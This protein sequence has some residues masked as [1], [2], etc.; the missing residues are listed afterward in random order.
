LDH[1]PVHDAALARHLEHLGAGEASV[2]A[3][4]EISSQAQAVDR[5]A[6]A[7]ARLAD[8]DRHLRQRRALARRARC[9]ADDYDNR[10]RA[11]NW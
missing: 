1:V 3:V 7:G 6:V 2:A 5:M 9:G 4:A 8:V 11:A 10:S